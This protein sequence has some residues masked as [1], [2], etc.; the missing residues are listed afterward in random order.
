MSDDERAKDWQTTEMKRGWPQVDP[1]HRDQ[2]GLQIS[3]TSV[4][5]IRESVVH[6]VPV[7]KGVLGSREIFRRPEETEFVMVIEHGDERMERYDPARH[8][9][10]QDIPRMETSPSELLNQLQQ[11]DDREEIP[12]SQQFSNVRKRGASRTLWHPG[13]HPKPIPC[14]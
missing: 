1:E 14:R 5:N 9:P 2:A 11:A 12:A 7:D 10:L 8:G 13:D 6:G 4:G 3:G